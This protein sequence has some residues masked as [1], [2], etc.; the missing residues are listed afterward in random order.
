ML[1]YDDPKWREMKAGYRILYDPT[2]ALRRLE[3]ENDVDAVWEE[4]WTELHHQGAVGEASY[5]VVPHLV[6]I[7][8]EKR[9]LDWNLYALVSTIE[10]ERKRKGNPPI[11][12]WLEPIYEDALREL[13]DLAVQDLAQSDDPLAVQTILGFVALAKGCRKLG[14]MICYLDESLINEFIE[15]Y[16]EWSMLYGQ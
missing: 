1:P 11:P 4:L 5:A 3:G 15:E 8:K 10:I 6:R 14:A 12:A 9:C 2:L 7:H 16:L 13:L